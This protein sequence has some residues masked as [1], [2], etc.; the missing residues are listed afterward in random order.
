MNISDFSRMVERQCRQRTHVFY[1]I[2]DTRTL[3]ETA[4]RTNLVIVQKFNGL[5]I[6]WIQDNCNTLRAR[7]MD[8]ITGCP[9]KQEGLRER[10]PK[11]LS[12]CRVSFY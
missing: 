8:L 5:N 9:I 7:L 11:H 6:C 1:I 4:E 12:A 10:N 2:D 3:V